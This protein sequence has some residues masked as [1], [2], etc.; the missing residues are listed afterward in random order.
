MK[1]TA[2]ATLAIAGLGVATALAAAMAPL[3]VYAL[4]L[5]CFG[6]PH[7]LTELRYV[8]ERFAGRL[9]ARV[10][11]GL[12]LLLLAIVA[13]RVAGLGGVGST[14]LRVGLELGLGA[15]LVAWPLQQCRAGALWP[16]LLLASLLALGVAT[17]P[18]TTM[19]LFA[20][21][22]NLTPIGFLAERLRGPQRAFALLGAVVAFV[23]VPAA[24]LL[25]PP[26]SVFTGPLGTGEL[27]LHLAVFVPASLHGSE[28]GDRL[29][30]IAAWW[31]C[32]HYALV[33]HVLPRV[34][35][36]DA[37]RRD[38][39]RW[40]TSQHFAR[41][42]VVAGGAMAVAFVAGFG[43]SRAVYGVFAAVHAWIELPVLALA[44]GMAIAPS[45]QPRSVPG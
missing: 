45:R 29:F 38:V 23:L 43:T 13:V 33:L 37:V 21:L 19:V 25:L 34:G 28:H 5:A 20:L 27:D 18:A 12:V 3:W 32:A 9:T 30:A 6:L 10:R 42:V 35:A 17:A 8:D 41:W 16:G 44:F 40:P 14:E 36:G 22:H 7:V 2:V 26:P 15:A 39:L 11:S 1:T 4:S 24:M 31:Q